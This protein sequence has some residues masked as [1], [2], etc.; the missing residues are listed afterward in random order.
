MTD[1]DDYVWIDDIRL[2]GTPIPPIDTTLPTVTMTLPLS[3]STI[4]GS[5]NVRATATDNI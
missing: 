4:S 2:A 1:G 5:I 3:G